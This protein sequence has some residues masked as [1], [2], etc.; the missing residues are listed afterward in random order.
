MPL[1]IWFETT[2]TLKQDVLGVFF[3]NK[4]DLIDLKIP[5]VNHLGFFFHFIN[6]PSIL[7][8]D[9]NGQSTP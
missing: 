8:Q 6:F 3:G 1:Y 9:A 4:K 7:Y 5:I 2:E